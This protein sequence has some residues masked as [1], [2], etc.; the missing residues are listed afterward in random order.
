VRRTALLPVLGVPF[1]LGAVLTL[2][3]VATG[4]NTLA[5]LFP[6]RV[7]SVLVPVATA[8]VLARLVALPEL[9]LD[10]VAAKALSGVAIIALVAGGLWISVN[11]LAFQN[12]NEDLA[13]MDFVRRTKKLGDLYF[14]PVSIPDLARSTRGS[15]SSDFKPLPDKR[16]DAR[17]IPVDLVR[18][19]L[20][21]GAPIFVD[22][23]SIP[24]QYAEVLE[25]DRRLRQALQVQD[26][27]RAGHT[28]EAL[29]ELRR[30]GV[31]H[32]VVPAS[33]PLRGDGVARVYGDDYYLVYRLRKR[34]PGGE[35]GA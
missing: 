23:K 15:L 16:S 20:Y 21:T 9:P 31:T 26:G 27:L 7:S 35:P 4:S 6:W 24:Y 5:L 29:A 1:V 2:V 33:C 28:A 8:V 22:F 17:V 10:G 3:Q 32:L 13:V 34:E 18:F 12:S 30:E 25:W 19:R 14:I 11:R